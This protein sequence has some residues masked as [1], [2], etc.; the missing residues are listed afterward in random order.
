[1]LHGYIQQLMVAKLKALDRSASAGG[2][3]FLPRGIWCNWYCCSILYLGIGTWSIKVVC[4]KLSVQ[5]WFY[6]IW[7]KI[8]SCLLS[9]NRIIISDGLAREFQFIEEKKS[10]ITQQ[11]KIWDGWKFFRSF[12]TLLS[13]WFLRTNICFV[14]EYHEYYESQKK[15]HCSSSGH[16][17]SGK[18]MYHL[19]LIYLEDGS[20]IV[21]SK[22]NY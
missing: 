20:I 6:L 14:Q 10:G 16:L 11:V 7:R 22:T 1:M 9:S 21:N 17:S 19:F 12:A 15:L 8:Q 2:N 5:A 13:R 18:D 3:I 4:S